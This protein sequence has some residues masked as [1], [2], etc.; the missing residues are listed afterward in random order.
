M[1]DDY[2]SSEAIAERRKKEQ[3]ESR[4]WAAK[5]FGIPAKSI[6]FHNSGI[7]Y[8]TIV[9]KTKAAANKVSKAV[10][11]ESANGGYFHGMPL[12]G[13]VKQNDGTIRVYC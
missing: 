3:K 1:T 2:W 7:C 8:D 10:K 4:E 12:G 13:Q 9:V 11:G 6:L 5:R